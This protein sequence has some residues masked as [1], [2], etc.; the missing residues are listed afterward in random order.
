MDTISVLMADDEP[1]M[2]EELLSL[3]ECHPELEVVAV[4]HNG[5]EALARAAELRP[6]VL[7]LD[8]QMPGIS[9]LTVADL[10]CRQ[11]EGPK[12]VFI[13]A[14]DEYAVK[15]FAVDAVDYVLKPF[16]ERDL[17]R[18]VPK[19]IRLLR[20][21]RE[22][23]PAKPRLPAGGY[24]LRFAVQKGAK[25]E[26]V[27]QDEIRMIFAKD[28]L[29]FIRTVDGGTYP[30]RFTLNDLAARLDPQRFLRCHR[31]YLVNLDQIQS[32]ETW[33]NRGY[34]L[35]LKD[36]TEVPVSRQYVSRLREH[37]EF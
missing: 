17:Q 18:V 29:V 1:L 4:C 7:F 12:V 36:R 21:A 16:D 37:L 22:P 20:G 2:C 27:N 30:I 10:L 6:E 13:T 25:L 8:I 14:H 5:E 24:L 15:A 9:G 11:A 28:R 35:F 26:V 3:L 33:F 23:V 31:N 34:L 32:L 19:L